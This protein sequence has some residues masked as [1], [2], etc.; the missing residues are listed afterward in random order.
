VTIVP[1]QTESLTRYYGKRRGVVDLT[2]E[3]DEAPS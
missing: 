2:F 3:V 1:I